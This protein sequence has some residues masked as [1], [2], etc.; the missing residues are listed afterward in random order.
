MENTKSIQTFQNPDLGKVRIVNID[1]LPYFAAKDV[2]SILG[3]TN[4]Q[5]AVRDHVDVED[6]TVN[7]AFVVHG[8]RGTLINESGLYS[9]ILS[10]RL[11]KAKAF[12]RWVTS[13]VLPEIRM[14]GTFQITGAGDTALPMKVLTSEDYL[15]A[16]RLIASC[17]SDRLLIVLDLLTKGGW[18]IKMADTVSV[19]TSTAGIGPLIDRAM[20]EK[21]MTYEQLESYTG[22]SSS[23]LRSYRAGRRYPRPERY[24]ILLNALN[25]LLDDG[26]DTAWQNE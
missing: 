13:E 18:D 12:K 10:S 20:N 6:M 5:K 23:V 22:V 24:A 15:A 4:P 2:A 1:G 11:P 7:D 21:G 14:N 19:N 26:G 8:T 3:Y 17:R 9:L 25:T 16:A